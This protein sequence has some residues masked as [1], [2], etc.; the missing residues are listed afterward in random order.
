MI[1][2]VGVDAV[3]VSRIAGVLERHGERFA[4]RLLAPFEHGEYA[5]APDAPRFLAKRFAVKEAFAKALG[6]GIAQ[7][8][9][10]PDIALHHHPGGQPYL[11]VHG[12][13][14]AHMQARGIHATH[15][16]LTDEGDLVLAFVVLERH[17]SAP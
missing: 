10:L 3:A 8:V 16:S 17:R 12:G 2:G 4:R 15:V 6:T 13:A 9:I 14:A 1:T 5:T 11:Q 7:D